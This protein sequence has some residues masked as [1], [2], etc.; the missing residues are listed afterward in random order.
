MRRTAVGLADNITGIVIGIAVERFSRAVFHLGELVKVIVLITVGLAADLFARYVPVCVV[1]VLPREVAEAAAVAELRYQ[2]SRAGSA[3]LRL[4]GV[5]AVALAVH[6][7]A[8]GAHRLP[9]EQIYGVMIYLLGNLKSIR[10]VRLVKGSYGINNSI[11]IKILI[12]IITPFTI[13]S[14]SLLKL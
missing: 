4:E 10:R 13:T 2:I 14:N 9:R 7:A 3:R 11:H 8:A 5:V 6:C 12:I 1:G